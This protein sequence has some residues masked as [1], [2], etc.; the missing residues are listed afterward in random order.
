MAG[1]LDLLGWDE[2]VSGKGRCVSAGGRELAI[3]RVEGELFAIDNS[4]P[5]RGGP[6][7]EGDVE[8]CV[9]HCPLHAWGFDLRTGVSPSNPKSRVQSYPA[10][11]VGGRVEV[12]LPD[13]LPPE[14]VPIDEAGLESFDS[15]PAAR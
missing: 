12:E 11:I 10:R 13:P 4:C 7:A 5:H 3:F 6:L 15:D 9:V 1:Y 14:P 2:L 8:G